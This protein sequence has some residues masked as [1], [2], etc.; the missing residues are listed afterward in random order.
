LVAF[1]KRTRARAAENVIV[2]LLKGT[3]A[4]AVET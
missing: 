1:T 4:A 2:L 3:S